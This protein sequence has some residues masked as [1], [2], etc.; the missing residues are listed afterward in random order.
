MDDVGVDVD[1]LASSSQALSSFSMD[2]GGDVMVVMVVR[3]RQP[4]GRRLLMRTIA[5][6]LGPPLLIYG[7]YT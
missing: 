5:L 3:R 1:A 6:G 4:S 2:G 7:A